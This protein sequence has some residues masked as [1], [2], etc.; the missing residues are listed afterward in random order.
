MLR[1]NTKRCFR[2]G[3]IFIC[4]CILN[5]FYVG[6]WAEILVQE[7]A[8]IFVIILVPY[9]FRKTRICPLEIMFRSSIWRWPR[10]FRLMYK[11]LAVRMMILYF[12]GA[13]LIVGKGIYFLMVVGHWLFK[14][15][16][17]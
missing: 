9:A 15:Y 11:K 7:M 14:L 3:A 12:T 17:K 8:S 6:G 4:V 13:V 1:N 16:Q 10:V 5:G 2:G